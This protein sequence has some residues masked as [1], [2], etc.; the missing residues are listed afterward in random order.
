MVGTGRV[1]RPQPHY[2]GSWWLLHAARIEPG[3]EVPRG[4]GRLRRVRV[5]GARASEAVR[6][7]WCWRSCCG[8]CSRPRGSKRP[9]PTAARVPFELSVFCLAAVTPFVANVS[10][11]VGTRVLVE[12]RSGVIAE[13]EVSGSL[14]TTTSASYYRPPARAHQPVRPPDGLGAEVRARAGQRGDQ[15]HP[16]AARP[17]ARAA[18]PA[19]GPARRLDR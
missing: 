3:V 1:R 11:D 4:V 12:S 2:D 7:L 19:P 9:L 16:L 15:A 8:G 14:M 10:A 18:R 6:W 5:F 13:Y 17:A